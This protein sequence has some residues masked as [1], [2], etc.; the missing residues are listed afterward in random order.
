MFRD[1]KGNLLKEQI[2]KKIARE[3]RTCY[4]CGIKGKSITKEK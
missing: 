1:R 2:Q 4:Q 3:R